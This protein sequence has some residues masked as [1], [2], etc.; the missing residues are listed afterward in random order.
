MSEQFFSFNSFGGSDCTITI[1][2]PVLKKVENTWNPDIKT[3]IVGNAAAI[4]GVIRV[5]GTPRYV[6]G[7]ADPQGF[8]SGKRLISGSL[9]LETLNRSFIVELKELLNK[10]DYKLTKNWSVDYDLQKTE[11][12]PSSV[13]GTFGIKEE[14]LIYADQLPEFN[15]TIMLTKKADPNK[16]VKRTLTGCKF[17]SESSG[18]GLST[19]DIQ[20]QLTF[21]ARDITA[22]TE[23]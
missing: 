11:N 20:E 15:I 14:S 17:V 22:M 10:E 8:S 19:L 7:E 3:V 5:E 18:I 1:E 13:N 9:V 2:I 6:M 23:A 21:M 4:Q 16:R 12:V